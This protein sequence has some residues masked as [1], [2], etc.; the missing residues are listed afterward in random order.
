MGLDIRL[1]IGLMFS[2]IGILL[3]LFGLFG[4]KAIY[5]RSLEIN[6]NLWWGIVM[7]IFGLAML[8]LGRRGTRRTPEAADKLDQ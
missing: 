5:Q 2:L 3:T 8:V 4:D 6:V 7:L 1:P